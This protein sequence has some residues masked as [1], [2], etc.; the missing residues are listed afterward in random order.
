MQTE[1]LKETIGTEPEK[2][3]VP[4][5]RAT[6]KKQK[7]SVVKGLR[8]SSLTP[9]RI[10]DKMDKGQDFKGPHNQVFYDSVNQ[11]VDTEFRGVSKRTE[12]F[13]AFL[14]DNNIKMDYLIK[15]KVYDGAAFTKE[16]MIGVYNAL[17]NRESSMAMFFGN[18]ISPKTA[19]QIVADLSPVDK[20]IGDYLIG[21]YEQNYPRL[22]EAFVEYTDGKHEMGQV[23]SYAPIKRISK[24]YEPTDQELM[25]EI[26]ER[27]GFKKMYAERG[28]TYA[29]KDIPQEYQ[30]PIRLDSVSIFLETIVK[31]EHFITHGNLIKQLHR[32]I[33]NKEY[34]ESVINNPKLGQPYIDELDKYV[35]RIANPN[36][37]KSY[38][39]IT[40]AVTTLRGNLATVYL[41]WN[42]VT[43]GKQFPSIALY[44]G[45]IGEAELMGAFRDMSTDYDNT[46]KFVHEKSSQMKNRQIERELEEL[47]NS[48]PETYNRILAKVGKAGFQG[49]YMIDRYVTHGGWLAAY[50]QGLTQGM[51]DDT[52]AREAD[53]IV[54][55]TQPAAGP[56]DIPSMYATNEFL[57]T[58]LQFTNQLN[59]IYNNLTYDIPA[60]AGQGRYKSAMA[61]LLGVG[62]SSYLIWSMS[63]GRFPKTEEE[64]K[65]ALTD[66]AISSIPIA[67][68]L[69]IS[70]REGFTG[71][72]PAMQALTEPVKALL[73]E[74]KEYEDWEDQEKARARTVQSMIKI[75]AIYKKIPYAQVK[76]TVSG[77]KD[78]ME[79]TTSDIRRLIWSEYNLKE[80][81]FIIR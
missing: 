31:Q 61:G 60:A 42:M 18:N 77:I 58:L 26:L 28:F 80:E 34:R 71:G 5:T 8:L 44:G 10:F 55:M 74:L 72:S 30:T 17:K 20:M 43:M 51:S 53:K 78:L 47:K 67:G 16:E 75:I 23:E 63:H 32:I 21:D 36:M 2:T 65:H 59:K 24:T 76:R 6:S 69:Y 1:L 73:G 46:V 27:S 40:K 13:Y 64:V 57:N 81:D 56:K 33:G 11:A 62:V 14:K 79:G 50:R 38:D 7:K 52:A 12:D 25:K 37:Y 19:Q 3:T 41:S 48:D 22:N 68:P 9:T 45:K 70:Q 39:A 29:R 4:V 49:I 35:N 66:S 54:L 15:T